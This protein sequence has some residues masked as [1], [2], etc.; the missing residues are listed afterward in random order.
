MSRVFKKYSALL[1]FCALL[2][3]SRPGTWIE[4]WRTMPE[5]P[6]RLTIDFPLDNSL[7][8]PEIERTYDRSIARFVQVHSRR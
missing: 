6:G 3:C 8:P 5:L 1:L 4:Q 7:F 2:S